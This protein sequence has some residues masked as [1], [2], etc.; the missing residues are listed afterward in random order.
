MLQDLRTN[1]KITSISTRLTNL[2]H[3][4]TKLLEGLG[5]QPPTPDHTHKKKGKSR[6]RRTESLSASELAI[7][8]ILA[9]LQRIFNDYKKAVERR[10]VSPSPQ[11]VTSPP[12]VK[13]PS[14]GHVAII[15][16]KSDLKSPPPKY[17][18]TASPKQVSKQTSLDVKPV[19]ELSTP[20]IRIR[21]NTGEE[22]KKEKRISAVLQRV[23]TLNQQS[24][25]EDAH[26]LREL[27]TTFGH[28]PRSRT[29]D[30]V[31]RSPDLPH[32]KVSPVHHSK[33]VNG[34]PVSSHE[35]SG[36]S[37]SKDSS[38]LAVSVPVSKDSSD[39]A[40]SAPASELST[41]VKVP[42]SKS[43][44]ESLESSTGVVLRKRSQTAAESV[45]LRKRG[46]GLSRVERR[47]K[48]NA[49]RQ[50]FESNS[51]ASAL[52]ST[53]TTESKRTSRDK[54]KME[55]SEGEA[56]LKDS[57]STKRESVD[58][59]TPVT[60]Q[61]YPEQSLVSTDI[62]DTAPSNPEQ[63]S[64][65]TDLKDTAPS[66][67]EQTSVST[68]HN[69]AAQSTPS[70]QDSKQKEVFEDPRPSLSPT[71][72][73]SPPPEFRPRLQTAP[74][75]YRAVLKEHRPAKQRVIPINMEPVQP[76]TPPLVKVEPSDEQS[77]VSP[78]CIE[79]A[80]HNA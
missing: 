61:S 49:I 63:T 80:T 11:P 33:Q 2:Q 15:R 76:I 18:K 62:K 59:N 7:K 35:P 79:V 55:T 31:I 68:D 64:V 72:L 47:E 13:S 75:V 9:K 28:R 32:K 43:M 46:G 65:S 39:L 30:P 69:D 50:I 73:V 23:V 54:S 58:S 78:V 1:L 48:I 16:R 26:A 8:Q 29:A 10:R 60:A 44:S 34:V 67:P 17:Q 38:D 40:V 51:L 42:T 74:T 71:V 27:G 20:V 6:A 19:N 37:V 25:R 56:N 77:V 52:S 57:L 53:T 41:S 24:T 3:E 36:Q 21:A 66:N 14:P 70:E 12:S 45:P 4:G 5:L 22:T